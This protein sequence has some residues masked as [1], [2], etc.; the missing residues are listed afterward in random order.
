MS[1]ETAQLLEQGI[2]AARAGDKARARR[3]L[4]E[5]TERDE[6][7]EQAWFWLSGVVEDMDEARICLENV[8]AIN[9]DN[10]KARQGLAW[11]QRRLEEQA[12]APPAPT[13]T[14]AP[15]PPRP[16]VVPSI[17]E[18]LATSPH[19]P[20]P[21]EVEEELEEGRPAINRLPCPACGALNYD[22]ATEC[23][24]CGFPFA[25]A[26]PSCGQLVSTETGFCPHC[27]A[28]L[29]LP[30]KLAPVRERESRLDEAYRQGLACMEE[31]NYKEAKVAFEEVLGQ[32][33]DHIEALYNLGMA[34]ARLNL[35]D[36]A[37][38]YWEEVQ[39]RQPDYPDIQK[40][41]DSLLSPRDRRR[42]AKER[43]QA[44]PRPKKKEAERAPAG[45]TL[46]P[47]F[48]VKKEDLPAPEEE[49]GGFE[50]FLYVLFA[51]LVVGVAYALNP[52]FTQKATWDLPRI[53]G[54]AKQA[55]LI[56]CGT[57][58]FWILL[59]LAARLVSLIFRGKGRMVGYAA[60]AQRFVMP[61]FLLIVPIVLRVPQIHDALPALVQGWIDQPVQIAP[62]GDL[63]PLVWLVFGGI[64]LFWGFFSL[65]RGIGR[66]GR[67]ALWKGFLVGLVALAIAGGAVFGLFFLADR[68]GVIQAVDAQIDN[69]LP[70]PTPT[71]TAQPTFA[72]TPT[73]TPPVTPMP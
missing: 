67:M 56:A 72:P 69:L 43:R 24:K 71:P 18:Q 68:Q 41:L 60:C 52:A 39:N 51:G 53:V 40:D 25:V 35:T 10:E 21:E 58:L 50:S 19:F 12:A 38:H 26:C 22:F 61:F 30:Q 65:V 66:V 34:C 63:P 11:V 32:R 15:P 29:A 55:A 17:E 64:A 9:P 2:A 20:A 4:I 1:E 59:F 54:V 6:R 47:S 62:L 7:S 8:L 44:R 33:P 31:R 73:A 14:P 70:K 23:V 27:D 5:V 16:P 48:E 37:R 36:E 28:E 45:Q 49:T 42:L 3:F 57:I 46:L 13:P